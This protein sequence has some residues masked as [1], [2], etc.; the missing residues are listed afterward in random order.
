[1]R[2]GL[3]TKLCGIAIFWMAGG[4]PL[5]GQL[6]QV[7]ANIV[8]RKLPVPAG[9]YDI[10]RMAFDWTDTARVD[11]ESD[12]S[13]KYRELMVYIWYPARLLPG[14]VSGEY[15]PSAGEV[16][17]NPAARQ[18]ARDEFGDA[19]P[20]IVGGAIRSH[21]AEGAPA[22]VGKRFPVILFS[23]GYSATTFSYTA[24]IEDFVSHGY[25]VVAIEHTGAA[26]LVRFADGRV[27]LFHN[28]R[29]MPAPSADSLQ[30]MI[31][32]AEQGTETGAEDDRF[33][34]DWLHRGATP[35]SG[36]MDL[37]KVAAVG[38]S[39]GGTL[40]ARACQI[41]PRLTACLS[42]EGE[43]NPV[44]AFFDYPDRA[45]L[46][47]PFL[48][49][50]LRQD[51]SD[52]ELARMH[53]PRIQWDHFIEHEREQLGQCGRGSYFV[54]VSRPGMAHASFSDGPILN[55]H[56]S[57]QADAALANLRLM[58]EIELAFLDKY[59]KGTRARLLEDPRAVPS[60]MQIEA[61][62]Q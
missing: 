55:A 34:L 36:V 13:Q 2:C 62:F 43:V 10:G 38:H 61:M 37:A 52:A 28:E 6:S 4:V 20:Q 3:Q 15:Y 14:A 47:Q 7:P 19:W 1:M 17:K 11:A 21:A 24:Q 44:G 49:M 18:A 39:A 31:A 42:E 29:I 27:R 48:L 32:S 23:H 50:Q 35:L 59:L 58:G 22:V 56:N 40:S 12:D 60:G 54:L 51:P 16:E 25:V 41:D 30:S 33:V 8:S 53:E 9:S 5:V 45:T 46:R 57:E 26:G